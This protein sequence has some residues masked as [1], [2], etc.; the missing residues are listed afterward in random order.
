MKEGKAHLTIGIGCTGGRHRSVVVANHL[1][2]IYAERGD[3]LIDVVH[4][5]VEKPPRGP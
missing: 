5:D 2:Q 1:A 3:Y 4:R